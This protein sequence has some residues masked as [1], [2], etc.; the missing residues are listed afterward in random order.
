M[1]VAP[2]SQA[3]TW[4][5]NGVKRVDWLLSAASAPPPSPSQ[6]W[7]LLQLH[8]CSIRESHRQ[9]CGPERLKQLENKLDFGVSDG[10]GAFHVE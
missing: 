1:R 9:G 8:V 7:L 2:Q 3:G 5:R 6:S 10:G 4:F